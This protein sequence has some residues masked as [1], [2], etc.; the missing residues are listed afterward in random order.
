[1]MSESVNLFDPRQLAITSVV[2]VIGIGGDPFE[3]GNF[4]FFNWEVPA[5]ASAAAP[6]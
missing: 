5:I 6:G 4:P 3:G 2:L 1:M